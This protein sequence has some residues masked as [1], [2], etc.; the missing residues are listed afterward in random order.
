MTRLPHEIPATGPAADFAAHLAAELPVI[1]TARLRLR[2]PR[3]EDFQAYAEIATGPSGHFLTENP[4][5][6]GAWLD[7]AQMTAT[8][9]LR[10]HGIWSVETRDTGDLAGFVVLG[11][12]PGDHEPELG[13]MFREIATGKGYATEAAQAARDYAF[14]TLDMTTLV[15]TIDHDNAASHRVAERLDGKRDAAAETAHNN[16]IRV[17]RHTRMEALA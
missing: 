1:E 9:L 11:F 5:R 13:Y 7:F 12:E 6:E 16:E 15:S 14:G 17:Y 8:W 4:D 10:G 3:I 2:A